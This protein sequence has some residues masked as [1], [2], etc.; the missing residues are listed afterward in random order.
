MKRIIYILIFGFI[1]SSCDDFLTEE[2]VHKQI[3]KMP[4]WIMTGHKTLSMECMPH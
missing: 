3:K 1:L 2:P 4:W